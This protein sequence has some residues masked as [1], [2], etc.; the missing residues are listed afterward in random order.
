MFKKYFKPRRV[1][2]LGELTDSF[3]TSL[4]FFGLYSSLSLTIIL[5]AQIKDWLL[6][7]LPWVNL[8]I[9]ILVVGF[10]LAVVLFLAYKYVIPSLWSS[11][12][13]RMTHLEMKIDL[14]ICEQKKINKLL[15]E[16][17]GK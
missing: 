8:W 6:V 12:S 2:Y 13:K 3:F 17:K 5:Y 16:K 11:R 9:F 4:P 15:K 10:A 7:W 1:K 14:I